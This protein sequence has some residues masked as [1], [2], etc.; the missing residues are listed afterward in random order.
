[1]IK[2]KKCESNECEER[3]LKKKKSIFE[4]RIA[5]GRLYFGKQRF[6]FSN[7]KTLVSSVMS[8]VTNENSNYHKSAFP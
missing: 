3:A 2:Q 4:T 1:M 5:K 6:G 8:Y 7:F